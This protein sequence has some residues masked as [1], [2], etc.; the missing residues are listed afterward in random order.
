MAPMQT[1]EVT[2]EAM[3]STWCQFLYGDG[4]PIGAC[5]W[6]VAAMPPTKA[7]MEPDT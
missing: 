5:S 7:A 4:I 3:T 1:I 6:M 2:M